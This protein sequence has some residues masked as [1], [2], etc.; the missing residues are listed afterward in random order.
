MQN[1]AATYSIAMAVMALLLAAGLA[2]VGWNRYT[3]RTRKP[4]T[5]QELVK[6]RRYCRWGAPALTLLALTYLLSALQLA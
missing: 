1:F 5:E 3:P 4:F 6:I 2:T